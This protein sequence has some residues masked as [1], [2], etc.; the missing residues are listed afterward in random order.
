M[1]HDSCSDEIRVPAT[2]L[3]E[4]DGL[5]CNLSYESK[6]SKD[7]SVSEI[8]QRILL[9]NS[10]GVMVVKETLEQ[11]HLHCF[12]FDDEIKSNSNVFAAK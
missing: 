2:A 7:D 6:V 5:L 10:A 11:I 3:F 1:E 8:V 9:W 12:S 4:A